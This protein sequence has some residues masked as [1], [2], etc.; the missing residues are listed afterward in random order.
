MWVVNITVAACQ[1]Q[2]NV[3]ICDNSSCGYTLMVIGNG[4]ISDGKENHSSFHIC[5][6]YI[7]IERCIL[8]E[9]IMGKDNVH[10]IS[11]IFFVIIILKLSP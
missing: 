11:E 10:W 5:H 9:S 3:L 4:E 2:V 7:R 1:V 8:V 6:K